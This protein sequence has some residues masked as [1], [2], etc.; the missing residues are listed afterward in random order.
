MQILLEK[1]E[2]ENFIR[3]QVDGGQYS[4][5]TAVVEAALVRFMSDEFAPGELAR[6]VAE[7]EASIAAGRVRD[8]DE[9]FADLRERSKLAR[10]RAGK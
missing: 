5:P 7:G 9:V 3:N 10:S 4:S 6:L 2:L 1:P 8:A